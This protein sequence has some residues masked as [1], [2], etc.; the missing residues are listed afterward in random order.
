MAVCAIREVAELE[1][2]YDARDDTYKLLDVNP[3]FWTWHSLGAQAGVDFPYLLWRWVNG[4][5]VEEARASAGFQ[6]V[7]L[8]AD[9]L[10]AGGEISRRRMSISEYLRSF[11]R[12]PEFAIFSPDDILPA[13]FEIPLLAV[14]H[15][16]RLFRSL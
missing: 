4:Q 10:A 7:H 9:L 15:G 5:S 16:G 13:I 1:F 11:S 8:A 12:V 14:R 3:R 6:W 2:K